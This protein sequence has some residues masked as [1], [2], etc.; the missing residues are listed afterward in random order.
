[1]KITDE[2]I[3]YPMPWAEK[4][5]ESAVDKAQAYEAALGE[6]G[7]SILDVEDKNQFANYNFLLPDA[8]IY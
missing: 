4:L 2:A 5:E 6:A 1:M 3:D 7:F 8:L